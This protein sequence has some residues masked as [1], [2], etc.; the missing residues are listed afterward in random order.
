MEVR[1]SAHLSA[2]L[3]YS[4]ED[5]LKVGAVRPIQ[6]TDYDTCWV[7]WLTEPDGGVAYPELLERLLERQHPDG[8]WGAL[9]PTRTIAS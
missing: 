9:S 2:Y 4:V 8:S 7:A 5:V 3:D 6:P 1:G